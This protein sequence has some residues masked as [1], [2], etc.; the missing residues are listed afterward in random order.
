M[1]LTLI[2][3]SYV[4]NIDQIE[5]GDIAFY[6]SNNNRIEFSQDSTYFIV[7][8]NNKSCMNCFFV[9]SGY[10]SQIEKKSENV[11]ISISH[12]DS[13]VLDRKRNIYEL[14]KIFPDFDRFGVSYSGKWDE[15]IPSPELLIIRNN[16]TYHFQYSDLFADG[17]E[18]IA[19]DVQNKI[20]SILKHE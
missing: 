4:S 19:I 11:F 3:A 20:T 13:S 5:T 7:L 9:L 8:K 6:S 14:T 12:S 17:F 16:Q 15:R 10:L 2:G 1:F 18:M